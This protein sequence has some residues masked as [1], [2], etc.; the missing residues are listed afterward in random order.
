M[1][2]AVE[3]SRLLDES[4]AVLVR[5]N[6]HL[7]YRLPNGQTFVAAKTPSDP[8]RAAKNNLSQLRRALGIVRETPDLKGEEPAMPVAVAGAPA[9]ESST[10]APEEPPRKDSLKERIEAAITTEEAIQEKL[11]GEAQAHERRVH[12][13]KALLPFTDDPAIED[14][15]R[16]VLPALEPAPPKAALPPEPPQAI[17]ERVQ[18][19]R[20]L[21]LAATQTFEDT[22]TVNDV[23]GLMTGGRQIDKPERQRVRSSVL[24]AMITLRQHGELIMETQAFGKRQATWRKA[25]LNRNSHRDGVGTRA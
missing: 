24:G 13:L 18:V 15:L 9:N 5:Q 20:Q 8:A 6:K 3:V 7:V 22:F 4:G 16:G 1:N 11:L 19:T 12:M 17:T 21:V 2:A 14:S 25:V 10:Q 23:L